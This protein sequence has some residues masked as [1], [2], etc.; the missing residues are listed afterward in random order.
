MLK[1]FLE[2]NSEK[3]TKNI[4][5]YFLAVVIINFLFK[6]IL[7]DY[8]S[9]W[10]DEIISLQSAYLDFGHIKHVSEWD[11]NPPFYYYCLSVWVKLLNDSEFCVRLLSVIF[12]SF[13][14]GLL[15]LLANK[16]INKTTAIISSFLYL[17]NN[18]LYFYS[19]E[20][21]AYSLMA[22]LVLLSS[23]F[24]LNFKNKNDW[25][26]I[27]LLGLINFLICYTH[28]IPTMVIGYQ[29]LL[30][31]FF[32]NKDQKLKFSYSL[33]ITLALV[34]LRFTKK[35]FLLIFAFTDSNNTFW[36][37]KSEFSYLLEVLSEF[38]YN[39]YLIVPFLILIIIGLTFHCKNKN[40]QTNLVIIYSLLI[41]IVSVVFVYLLGKRVSIFLDRYLIFTV[42]FIFILI[43]YTLS[44]VKYKYLTITLSFMFFLFFMFR[45]DYATPKHMEYK[46]AM[47]F[48]NRIKTN[49]DLIIVKTKGI[50]PLFGYYYEK[51][52]LKNQKK[53][54]TN[55]GNVL[56]C[57]SWN[58]VTH[59][60]NNYKRVI[61]MDTYAAYNPEEPEFLK[62]L[63]ER[64]TKYSTINAYRG[65]E[66]S[67]YK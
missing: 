8:S 46:N 66:I 11:N 35:Q 38:F 16:Y 50:M 52:F 26:H 14:A 6:I 63:S 10:Y 7:L 24:Y 48:V 31:F 58:D 27:L 51:D 37:K 5:L 23:Y 33:L 60:V 28:Y 40:S 3:I 12:S 42:P 9:F 44:Y 47:F 29:F 2:Y 4:W 21:R 64:K 67:F 49:E 39:Y 20:A 25:K 13:A 19:H 17:C 41:G 18:F 22:L 54:L 45:I 36:L 65:V 56:V 43:G 61:V 30:M 32:F 57:S 53:E 59:D 1:S 15:F 55:P 62:K 34:L